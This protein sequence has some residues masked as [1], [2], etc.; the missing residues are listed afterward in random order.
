MEVAEED[1]AALIR[2]RFVP[3]GV[4][5]VVEDG[6]VCRRI[7]VAG[8][9][10]LRAGDDG[11]IDVV[12]RLRDVDAR[13]VRRRERLDAVGVEPLRELES[14]CRAGVDEPGPRAAARAAL[15]RVPAGRRVPRGVRVE[16]DVLEVGGEDAAALVRVGADAIEDVTV[17]LVGGACAAED[18]RVVLI[19]ICLRVGQRSIGPRRARV[20]AR[21]SGRVA[22]VV[23]LV[24]ADASVVQ[25]GV[26]VAVSGAFRGPGRI[27]ELIVREAELAEDALE[28]VDL[29]GRDRDERDVVDV[30]VAL[31]LARREARLRR[32]QRARGA[33]RGRRDRH[34]ATP[35]AELD[36]DREGDAGGAGGADERGAAR[37]LVALLAGAAG[38]TRRDRGD[39]VRRGRG[40][41]RNVDERARERERPVRRVD[42]AGDP[43]RART[44]V[45]RLV[46]AEAGAGPGAG[47]ADVRGDRAADGAAGAVRTALHEAAAAVGD[48]AAAV[49]R[50]VRRR[51][52]RALI[53]AAAH[54]R[55]AAAAADR[56]GRTARAVDDAAAAVRDRTA[57]LTGLRARQRLTGRAAV[58]GD[59]AA[60]ADVRLAAAAADLRERAAGA[61]SALHDATAAVGDRAAV[62]SR[63]A[64]R[65]RRARGRAADVRRSAA[66]ADRPVHARSRPAVQD[67]AAAVGDLTALAGAARSERD[68]RPAVGPLRGTPAADARDAAAAADLRSRAGPAARGDAAAPVRLR[69]TLAGEVDARLRR[70]RATAGHGALARTAA[71]AELGRRALPAV[72]DST[73][74]VALLSAVHVLRDVV[75]AGLRHAGAAVRRRRHRGHALRRVA[76][77]SALLSARTRSAREDATAAVAGEPALDIEL[78]ARLRHARGADV[79]RDALR[80]RVRTSAA[81]AVATLSAVGDDASAAVSGGSALDPLFGARAWLAPRVGVDAAVGRHG[82]RQRWR[83]WPRILG[84]IASVV[85]RRLGLR[86]TGCNQTCGERR[87]DHC[88]KSTRDELTHN[89]S[90]ADSAVSRQQSAGTSGIF[91]NNDFSSLRTRTSPS[92]SAD[93]CALVATSFRAL[94]ALRSVSLFRCSLAFVWGA[95]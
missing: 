14:L 24:E 68:A 74:A 41:V 5:R 69:S 11:L 20:H 75:G 67:A 1:A 58:A 16:V 49:G 95:F 47:A 65:E 44:A 26:C 45:G 77:P 76:G 31:V 18:H 93:V 34:H 48:V 21:A 64:R 54:A 4:E 6:V 60:A 40:A 56:G 39:A 8:D 71:T 55:D 63:G 85:E 36:D 91:S 19:E 92:F 33:R 78:R 81:K 23:V 3:R 90:R 42:L 22:A 84:S 72:D 30:V 28:A 12:A 52:R 82:R 59:A 29:T 27:A 9:P 61:G 13:R 17:P 70:A 10:L 89:Y 15:V 35:L 94:R 51:L 66:A 50:A 83:G 86:P 57:L 25:G 73:A 79:R 32:R 37:L 87:R 2:R 53:R 80:M 38:D 7:V 88:P 46:D 62:H 43:R